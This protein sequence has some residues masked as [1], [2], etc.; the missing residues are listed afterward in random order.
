MMHECTVQV[1]E[2]SECSAEKKH[3][4]HPYSNPW[5]QRNHAKQTP[6]GT[7]TRFGQF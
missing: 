3:I 7:D 4:Y 6:F 1:T 5:P 2:M